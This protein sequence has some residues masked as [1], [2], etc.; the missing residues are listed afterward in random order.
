[1]SDFLDLCVDLRRECAVGGTGPTTVVDQTGELERLVKWIRDAYNEIQSE[2]P[3]WRWLRSEFTFQ[4]VAG[5]D[6]YAYGDM[7]DSVASAT[8]TRFDRFWTEEVQIYLTSAGIGGRHHIPYTRWEDFRRVW[9][10]GNPTNQYPSCFSID[11]RD[12]FRL[13]GPPGAVYTVTGEYQKSPQVLALDDDTP[14][15]PA[16][17]HP[18]IVARAMEKYAAYHAAP[19]VDVAAQRIIDRWMPDLR[20]NQLPESRLAPPL[21]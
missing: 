17:Y 15:M 16:K 12:N 11:P 1:M 21:C 20:A 13:G 8:I 7:T 3:N 18:L 9:L 2:E 5:D 4:T 6:S 19:E 14:E 10:T